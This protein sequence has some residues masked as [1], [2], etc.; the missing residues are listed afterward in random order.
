[1]S[2]MNSQYTNIRYHIYRELAKYQKKQEQRR[3]AVINDFAVP[4]FSGVVAALA[5]SV[6][7]DFL[8][9]NL[10]DKI[11]YKIL[12]PI[13]VYIIVLCVARKIVFFL[14]SAGKY[15]LSLKIKNTKDFFDQEDDLAA[16]FNYEVSY[17][18]KTA[19]LLTLENSEDRWLLKMNSVEACFYISN[20]LRKIS[21]SI[22]IVDIRIAADRVSCN[23]V[24]VVMN[25]IHDALINIENR[26]YNIND[27]YLLKR[28]YE[29][30][31]EPIENLY[32][33]SLPSFAKST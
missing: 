27:V 31:R 14:E 8:F 22:L 19:Y 33:I 12:I 13:L 24:N 21:E 10:I 18:V 26:N 29:N 23:R 28:K 15:F 1:M 7:S 16:K 5:S 2:I 25:M 17:L 32:K 6:C 3:S 9:D 30:F 4:V 20:A 11:I